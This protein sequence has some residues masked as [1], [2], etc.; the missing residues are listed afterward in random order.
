[1][2]LRLAALLA[3]VA[4]LA[5]AGVGTAHAVVAPQ[6][7]IISIPAGQTWCPSGY[8]CLFRDYNYQGGGYGFRAGTQ[9]RFLGDIGFNDQMSSWANDSGQR[10]CWYFDADFRGEV[11]DMRPGFRVNVTSWENDKASSLRPC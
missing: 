8:V 4:A 2:K 7:P 11:H 5:P 10:Y 3:A 1:M 6:D 9:I